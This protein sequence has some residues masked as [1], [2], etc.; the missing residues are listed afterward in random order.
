M[1]SFN[2]VNA[3]I[4]ESK[5][6]WSARRT[7]QSLMSESERLR[8]LGVV[9]NAAHLSAAMAPRA[10]VAAP[11]F[12]PAIDW[13]N[14]RGNH[15]TSVKDQGGCG[16]CV[17][18]CTVATVESLASIERGWTLDL[19]EADLHFCSSHGPSCAGWWPNDAYNELRNRGYPMKRVSPTAALSM[20]G[21][22]HPAERAP[23][24]MPV[25][26]RLLNQQP[27]TMM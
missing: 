8:L 25:L 15:V 14:R 5:A 17:S 16:S 27:S 19:S 9:V 3:S 13:R 2:E 6:R 26:C 20:E 24:A 22:I 11:N 7:P 1:V 23:T 18:F 10:E 12:E 4:G 21:A